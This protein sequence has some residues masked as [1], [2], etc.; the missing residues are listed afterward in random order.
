[1]KTD[2]P[3]PFLNKMKAL[4]PPEEWEAFLSSY[5]G[6]APK[7]LRVNTLKGCFSQLQDAYDLPLSP[8]SWEPEGFSYDETLAQPGKLVLHEAGAY[9]I[10]EPSAMLP[11]TLLAVRP[12]E[13]VLDLCAAPGGKTLQLACQLDGKGL[14]LSNEIHPARA[15]ILSENT[16]RCGI[17]NAII[18]NETSARLA[19]RFPAFFDKVLVDAPC[20]GEGMFRKNPE[21]VREWSPENVTLC[22]ARQ[23]EILDHAAV[24]LRPGGRL[25]Y[26]TCT[27][28]PEEDE[29]AVSRFLS[30]HPDFTL[31]H[32]E[33][34]L[35]HKVCGD[36]QFAA[37]LS[38]NGGDFVPDDHLPGA[39]FDPAS[40]KAGRRGSGHAASP[41]WPEEL[42][43]LW[44]NEPAPERTVSFGNHLYLLPEGAFSTDGLKILRPGLCLGEWKKDRFEPDHALALALR[45][46]EARCVVSLDEKE[47]VSYLLGNTISRETENGWTLLTFADYSLGFGKAVNSVIKNHYPKGLRTQ[48]ALRSAPQG[49]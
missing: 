22:A 11:A 4:L 14:L 27:F 47:A 15:K 10:Q 48:C 40:K 46:E 36:G 42:T 23:D 26:S 31:S 3:L 9:Y 28:S 33:K 17:R 41:V 2:L 24:M 35:P 32:M 12:G 30:R 20:S 8:V 6:P 1:M 19:A 21:A 16:E 18:C 29:E 5:D 44:K 34:L 43:A 37:V 13:K 7:G 49:S 39:A 25:V 45:P 38:R